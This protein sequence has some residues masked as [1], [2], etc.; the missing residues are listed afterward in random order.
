MFKVARF[1]RIFAILAVVGAGAAANADCMPI[2]SLPYQ[3]SASGFYCV[4]ADFSVNSDSYKGDT[5]TVDASNVDIDFQ[6]HTVTNTAP[7]TSNRGVGVRILNFT[8]L[9]DVTIHNVSLYWFEAGV[10]A[11]NFDSGAQPSNLTVDHMTIQ[12]TRTS[13]IY[14]NGINLRVTNN[15]IN[16][17]IGSTLAFGIEL[18][19]C[20]PAPN[21]MTASNRAVVQGN[22]I[23]GVK[24][25]AKATDGT[26]A[27]ANALGIYVAGFPNLVIRDNAING[28]MVQ[29][30][31]L[32][33]S[34]AFG[35]A[36]NQMDESHQVGGLIIQDNIVQNNSIYFRGSKPNSS[37]GIS[38]GF[39]GDHAIV[40]GSTIMG[41]DT[42]ID[43]NNAS[44]PNTPP[45]LLL[46]NAITA[47]NWT[48]ADG[49]PNA[50][51]LIPIK[52]GV[53]LPQ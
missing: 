48:N 3:V 27:R 12:N 17:V 49:V 32:P 18:Q 21:N 23:S 5:I 47:I 44:M 8:A 2:S 31:A 6:G 28:V 35:I 36:I 52:G 15:T 30:T 19:C 26:N 42:G 25:S 1:F 53:T 40:I 33:G 22:I 4:T 9:H 41:M 46:N 43:A 45:V 7:S 11:N 38:I 37:V 51:T 14:L 50:A 20:S 29:K 10:V 39:P 13:G 16:S 34:G 24:V